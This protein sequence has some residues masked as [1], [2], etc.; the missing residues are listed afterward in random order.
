MEEWE[1]T[2]TLASCARAWSVP[3]LSSEM[4]NDKLKYIIPGVH[5]TIYICFD[6]L[7]FPEIVSIFFDVQSSLRC[8]LLEEQPF[9][10]SRIVLS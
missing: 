8:I 5:Y 4:G 9:C 7:S 6:L 3:A 1:E 2:G 10:S